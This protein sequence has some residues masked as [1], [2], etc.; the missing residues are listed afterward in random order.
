MSL[1]IV[2]KLALSVAIVWL[3]LRGI[4]EKLLLA[5][6]RHASIWWLLWA[7]VWFVLSKIVSAVR[8]NALL[9]TENIGLSA[10]QILASTG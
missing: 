9:K 8:F 2:L 10:Q 6:L 5:I 1:K 3:V 4:D 7:M